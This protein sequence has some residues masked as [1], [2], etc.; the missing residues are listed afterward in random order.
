MGSQVQTKLGP[1]VEVVL[2]SN[3]STAGSGSPAVRDVLGE[4]GGA[5][6]GRLVDLRV[7]PD[8]VRRPV[9]LDRAH[10]GSLGRALA[11]GSVLLD[12]VLDQ[13]VLGPAVHGHENSTSRVRGVSVKGNVSRIRNR[14]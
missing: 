14:S 13:R 1:R 4:S 2:G 5:D 7:L 6:N 9:A 12:V 8:V 11:V 10:L 3:S